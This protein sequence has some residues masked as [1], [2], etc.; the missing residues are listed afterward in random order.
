[1]P[2]YQ[3]AHYQ[4]RPDAVE[5]VK[6]AIIEFVEYVSRNE[7]G[8]TMYAAWQQEDDP[9]KFVHLFEFNDEAAQRA[10]GMSDAVRKFESVYSPELA[11]GPVAFTNYVL[12][13][14][15]SEGEGQPRSH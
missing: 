2:I 7:S 10:H 13:A 4:V 14:R 15:N 6:A 3:T 5:V 8:T 9:S 1:M 12:I 11:A